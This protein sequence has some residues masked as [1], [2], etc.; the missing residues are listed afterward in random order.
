MAL[1]MTL[2][3]GWPECDLADC[4]YATI[5]G[6]PLR[7]PFQRGIPFIIL[8]AFLRDLNDF[9]EPADNAR[10]YTDEGSWTEDNSVYTSNHKGATAFDYNW[11]DHPLGYAA[12]DPRAGWN[13]SVL[14]KGDQT[15]AVRELLAW[16]T[17]EGLQLVWW[18]NDWNSPKDS[19]HFQMGYGTATADGR[20]KAARFIDRFIRAD[21][22]STYRRGGVPRGGGAAVP[23]VSV[24]LTPA[25]LAKVMDNRVSM[26]RY[27]A[28]APQLIS[29]FHL[30]GCDTLLR[31]RHFLAQVGH[32]SGGLKYQEE[33]A[34]GAAYEGRADLGNT[35]RGDGVRFKGRDFIQITGRSNYTRLSQ[36]AYGR[37]QV[38]TPTF[39]V[40]HPEALA[41]DA[42]AFLGVV[43]YWTQARDM[44][45]LADRD[46]IVAVTKAVNGG[47][48][49]LEDRKAFY[50][51]AVAAGDNLLDPVPTDEWE[52]LMAD[53]QKD[54]SRS[55]Y[56]TDNN[57][58]FTARDMVFNADATTHG[59]W[60]ESA[61]LRGEQWAVELVADVA[62][63][64]GTGAKTWWDASKTDTWAIQ[65]AQ[66]VLRVIEATNPAA[67]ATYIANRKGSN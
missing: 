52:A 65:H 31:R 64:V 37:G 19:M 23:P 58:V 66:Q 43:W 29:A 60:V 63:G 14:I 8:Q 59:L 46:D 40:D 25:V 55:I 22:Y 50:A 53:G 33:I 32:E 17:F 6:T 42:Y 18:G 21:G 34:S 45:A 7:L 24:G 62:A 44:N 10:H 15:P 56:R 51:R 54:Q 16:Y 1:G 26:A 39:F 9:I 5:P 12:P 38:P 61:A 47:T 57:R 67:L 35:Q 4:D 48:N 49:G 2:E 36:W 30:A 27:E 3:N 28:L 20:A 13:G 41:T 11:S